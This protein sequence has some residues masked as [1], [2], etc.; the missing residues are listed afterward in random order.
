MGECWWADILISQL[1]N[2]KYNACF[3]CYFHGICCDTIIVRIGHN[4]CKIFH[5]VPCLTILQLV[6]LSQSPHELN[7]LAKGI[8]ILPGGPKKWLPYLEFVLFTDFLKTFF[9]ANCRRNAGTST[10]KAQVWSPVG[11]SNETLAMVNESNMSCRINIGVHWVLPVSTYRRG[12]IIALAVCLLPLG[13]VQ[14]ICISGFWNGCPPWRVML[15]GSLRRLCGMLHY[16]LVKLSP[17]A[18]VI[19]VPSE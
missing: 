15:N 9:W 10:F 2:W 11:S 8:T 16:S 6:L 5:H 4:L 17:R 18:K 19:T 1:T 13:D 7:N 12:P 14:C 3:L